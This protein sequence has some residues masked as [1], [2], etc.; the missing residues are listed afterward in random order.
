MANDAHTQPTFDKHVHSNNA[1]LHPHVTQVVKISFPEE[2]ISVHVPARTREEAH[3]TLGAI[4][5]G[6]IGTG[7]HNTYLGH[8]LPKIRASYYEALAVAEK[9]IGQRKVLL[10]SRLNNPAEYK[11]FV[12]WASRR[13]SAIAR[14]YRIPAGPGA[15]IGGELRDW[16]VYGAGGRSPANLLERRMNRAINPPASEE[17]ALTEMLSAV[18]R[19][20]A[21]E[22]ENILRAAKFLRRGGAVFLV[23]GLALTGYEIYRAKP[24]DRPELIRKEALVTGGSLIATDLAVAVAITLSITG[25]G[26]IA[27][28]I[29]AGVAGAIAAERMYYASQ[30]SQQIHEF[31]DVGLTQGSGLHIFPH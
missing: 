26:L 30:H 12:F 21:I 11:Q 25:V 24:G 6:G 27:V 16:R 19:P 22:T 9:E 15:M 4:G 20:N 29:I 2:L 28:G 18:S 14:I 10:G 5:S 7:L 13:R 8:A 1:L 3:K 31:H 17:A 23:G